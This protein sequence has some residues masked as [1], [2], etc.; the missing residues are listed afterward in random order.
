MTSGGQTREGQ[1]IKVGWGF[2]GVLL[3]SQVFWAL[4]WMTPGMILG[5]VASRYGFT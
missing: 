2:H 1:F 5:E 4:R 3:V